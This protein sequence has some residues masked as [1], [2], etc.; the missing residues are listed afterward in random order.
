MISVRRIHLAT[1]ALAAALALAACAPADD[2][3]PARAASP[4]ASPGSEGAPLATV[5]DHII[6]TGDVERRL[7]ALSP[8]ERARYSSIEQKRELVDNMIRFEVLAQEALR[9]GFGDHPDVVRAMKEVMIQKMMEDLLAGER[10]PGDIPEDELRAFYDERTE[11]FHR[12]EQVRAS[13]IVVDDEARAEALAAEA[14]GA[15]PR[16]FRELVEAHSI[17]AITRARGGDLRYFTRE[18]DE[19]PAP[20]I[21]AAFS[22]GSGEVK[23]PIASGDGSYFIIKRTGHRAEVERPFE[24]VMRQ[25]RNRVYRQNRTDA[26]ARF[27]DELR[28]EAEIEVSEDELR[29]LEPPTGDAASTKPSDH[30]HRPTDG[31]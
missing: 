27:I 7:G 25:L 15:S 4:T 8:Y 3:D 31:P 11:E 13:V 1:A 6:T 23:G 19:L 18:T 22:A 5:G 10:D 24:D 29:K 20:L 17:D 28:E 2:V 16:A 9:R 30:P 14:S 26:Q 12:P 21:D